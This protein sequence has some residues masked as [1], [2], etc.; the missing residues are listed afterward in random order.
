VAILASLTSPREGAAQN[1][2]VVLEVPWNITTDYM[3]CLGEAVEVNLIATVRTHF[4]ETQGGQVHYVEN[5][6]L[7]GTSTGQSSGLSWYGRGPDPY[8][9]NSNGAQMMETLI[10]RLTWEPLDGGRMYIEK[11]K[12]QFVTDANGVFR[13]ERY[14]PLEYHCVG[15]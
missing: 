5:W 11:L 10:A 12:I 14:E 2:M 3:D 6:F 7:E 1:G 9:T 15:P 8:V 13:V 4:I